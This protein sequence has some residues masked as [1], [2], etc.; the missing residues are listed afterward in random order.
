[1]RTAAG[2][3]PGQCK[4]PADLLDQLALA[5]VSTTSIPYTPSA[6]S[7]GSLSFAKKGAFQMLITL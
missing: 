5:I 2:R 1:M 4:L 7:A 3:S 6:S